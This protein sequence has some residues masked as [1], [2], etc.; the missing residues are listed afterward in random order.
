MAQ[1]F[2]GTFQLNQCHCFLSSVIHTLLRAAPMRC[3]YTLT[4]TSYVHTHT[5]I[6]KLCGYF[7]SARP[8]EFI[9]NHAKR[10]AVTAATAAA[11]S[12]VRILTCRE[13][14]LLVRMQ[15][16]NI[17]I[18]TG[19]GNRRLAA[20]QLCV[21]VCRTTAQQMCILLGYAHNGHPPLCGTLTFNNIITGTLLIYD[22]IYY[23][24]IR[25]QNTQHISDT[26]KRT[27][28]IRSKTIGHHLIRPKTTRHIER[29]GS[30]QKGAQVVPVDASEVREYQQSQSTS[31][32]TITATHKLH[33]NHPL[34]H[35]DHRIL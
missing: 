13:R 1:T 6:A 5:N 20:E 22:C 8:C 9:F 30:A 31:Q 27:R 28:N 26:D 32:Y 18:P 11:S 29:N 33:I 4:N 19:H 25:I 16:T 35:I 34:R 3:K 24:Y 17:R 12:S 2:P 7:C 21:C 10:W 14:R 23:E 15:T